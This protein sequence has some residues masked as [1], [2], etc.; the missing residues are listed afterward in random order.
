M[1]ARRGRRQSN[2]DA[3]CLQRAAPGRTAFIRRV[4]RISS[5]QAYPLQSHIHFLSSNLS[6]RSRYALPQFHLAAE[7]CNRAVLVELY[8][9]INLRM[10]LQRRRDRS[11]NRKVINRRTFD[12]LIYR[13]L[14][15][16]NPQLDRPSH[17]IVY[18]AATKV[19]RKRRADII[20]CRVTDSI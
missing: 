18:A 5:H 2:G 13:W 3:A 4:L 17:A 12:D 9:V 14:K 16:A 15:P 7:Y 19:I 6:E 1:L 10:P 11:S 8:P 20:V